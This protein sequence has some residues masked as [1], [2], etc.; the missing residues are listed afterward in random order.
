MG[1]GRLRKTLLLAAAGVVAHAA[2]GRS[3]AEQSALDLSLSSQSMST[4]EYL[5]NAEFL[6][7]D[8]L[9]DQ[10]TLFLAVQI[11]GRDTGFIGQFT[12]HREGRRMSASRAELHDIGLIPP[13]G[14]SR[15]VYLDQIPGL[16]YRYD[17]F[18]QD[19][20]I[21]APVAAVRP[22]E[23]SGARGSRPVAPQ[24]GYGAVLNYR[25]TA[26]LG[27]D[28]F[29]DG[30]NVLGAFANLEA[31]VYSPFGVLTTT[32]AASASS[33]DFGDAKVTRYDTHFTYSSPTR[34]LTFTAGDFVASTLP[35]GRPIRLGGVQFRR[36]FALRSDI[37]T[38][39][40]L[41]YT[42]VAA[43]PSTIDVFVDNVRAWSGKAEPGPFKLTDVPF[44]TSSGEAVIVIRDEAGNEQISR[45][46]FFAG[47]D[48][49]KAGTF[50]FSLDV[51]RP[52]GG[53][54]S[55]QSDYGEETVGMASLRY[56]ITDTLTVQAH[57][58]HGMG[59]SALSLGLTSILFN[60]AEATLAVGQSTFGEQ[61]GSIV[62][63]TVRSQIGGVGIKLSSQR[64][65]AEYADLAYATGIARLSEEA[66]PADFARMRP[67]Q[68]QDALTLNFDSLLKAGSFG[69]SYIHSERSDQKNSYVSASYSQRL[70]V[71]RGSL[72]VSGFTDLDE[73]D[74]GFS[75]GLSMTLGEQTYSSAGVSRSRTGNY[76]SYASLS[77]P[78]GRELGS[79]GYR[80]NLNSWHDQPTAEISG[81]YRTRYGLAELRLRSGQSGNVA[82]SASFDGALVVAGGAILPGNY[83]RDGFAVVKVGVPDVPVYLHSRE[84]A[85][86]G[87]FGAA[88]VADLQSYRNNRVSINPEDLPLDAGVTAT[89]MTV[90]PARKSGVTVNFGSGVAATALVTVFGADGKALPVGTPV[91]LLGRRDAFVVGYDGELWLEGLSRQ[92]TL[93]AALDTGSCSAEFAYA[94]VP[95]ELTLIEGLVCR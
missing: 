45:V 51:G 11:N 1:N 13:A 75:V 7:A 23:I 63:G 89:A 88:L 12:L 68:A 94:P 33:L 31:R 66:L 17:E 19:I 15:E 71:G 53:F 27:N 16:S 69:L 85:R 95:D 79:H 6:G 22:L 40:R 48:V 5:S 77:R 76:S 10:V 3:Y 26:N 29:G 47:R 93:T 65:T 72:R 42:G 73:G 14:A 18:R 57:A 9:M 58:E 46:P 62:Y 49:L 20:H 24:P 80:L 52:R 74:Y 84:V 67:A 43:V 25:V 78:V 70:P 86:T 44:V 56:G 34:M 59:V 8:G 83:V 55:A 50:D 2:I 41:S 35:W 39:P 87:V 60:A 91:R 37:I 90:V 64:S 82:A 36:D 32:G 21:S 81:A 38:T 61:S 54:G 4:A 30:I 92:N 28:L